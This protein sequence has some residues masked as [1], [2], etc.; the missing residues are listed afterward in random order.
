MMKRFIFSIFLLPLLLASPQT[1]AQGIMLTP[2]WTAQAQFTGYYVADKLGFYKEEGIDVCVQHP[3]ISESSFSFMEKGRAPVVIMNLSYAFME[4]L[5]GARVVNVM[6][7]SQENS[8]MLISHSPLKG[9]ESLRNQ[10]IAVWNHLSQKLL[11]RLAEH[12]ALKQV[13]CIIRKTKCFDF[14]ERN[15]LFPK[16]KRSFFRTPKHPLPCPFPLNFSLLI[17][18]K[19]FGNLAKNRYICIV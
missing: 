7:T 14:W 9:E 2:K 12:Y 8:L 5:A 13:E 17:I 11:D 19:K 15:V 10:K 6:Q 1:K 3:A 18:T 4:R 16:T